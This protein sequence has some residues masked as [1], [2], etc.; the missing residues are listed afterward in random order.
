MSIFLGTSERKN[1]YFGS[2]EI[3]KV[4]LGAT[5]VYASFYSFTRFATSTDD[6]DNGSSSITATFNTNGT[7]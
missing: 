3:K 4:Y 6:N 1:I 7:V 5:Q 2:T